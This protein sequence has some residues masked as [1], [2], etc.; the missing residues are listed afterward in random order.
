MELTLQSKSLAL[1]KNGLFKGYIPLRF[2][3]NQISNL[4]KQPAVK[5]FIWIVAM[6][7]L[8]GFE[9]KRKLIHSLTFCCF[10]MLADLIAEYFWLC[11]FMIIARNS[12]KSASIL[13]QLL[14]AG[15]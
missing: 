7:K 10:K 4:K 14:Y 12:N 3:T 2:W 15:S 5:G 9:E 8:E 6:E 1:A 11:R 13:K